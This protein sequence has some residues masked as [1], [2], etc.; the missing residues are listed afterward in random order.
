MNRGCCTASSK[1]NT[2]SVWVYF[3]PFPSTHML[4]FKIDSIA[5]VFSL[6]WTFSSRSHLLLNEF[7]SLNFWFSSYT[8]LSPLLQRTYGRMRCRAHTNRW[9]WTLFSIISLF[10][11]SWYSLPR[12]SFFCFPFSSP[13]LFFFCPITHS[14]STMV[15]QSMVWFYCEPWLLHRIL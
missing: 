2:L 12:T 3:F 6:S 15:I 7:L 4:S 13:P 10:F 11:Y 8:E 14:S 1:L 9:F 5:V